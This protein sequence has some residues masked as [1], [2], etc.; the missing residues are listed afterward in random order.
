MWVLKLSRVK[1]RKKSKAN[2]LPPFNVGFY[3]FMHVFGVR[4]GAVG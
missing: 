1:K 3:T 4:G 2:N